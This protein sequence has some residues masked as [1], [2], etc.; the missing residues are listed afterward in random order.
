LDQQNQSGRRWQDD[1][2][3]SVGYVG[4]CLAQGQGLAGKSIGGEVR[5]RISVLG[6]AHFVALVCASI[7]VILSFGG[8]TSKPRAIATL[9][10]ADASLH[11]QAAFANSGDAQS[12]PSFVRRPMY[13]YSVIPGGVESAQELK[14]AV[15]RD[16]V[17]A[18]HYADFDFA[19]A[20]VVRLPADRAMYASYRIGDRVFWTTKTLKLRK[21][22]AVLSD[23][24]HE[25]RARCGN[26]LSYTPVGPVSP[27]EPPARV[28]ETPEAP[29]LIA[30]NLPPAAP[31]FGPPFTPPAPPATPPG[32]PPGGIIPPVF[33]PPIGGGPIP[34]HPKPPPVPMP[35]PGAAPLLVIGLAALLS[36]SW[37]L[38]IRRKR[39]A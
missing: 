16:S 26:R 4:L 35:E 27:E 33:W 37:F 9:S 14:N 18:G 25:A 30:D 23:G 24:V 19:K 22:E 28:M 38:R 31:P 34:N 13:P 36:A 10:A 6:W 12:S 5:S 29:I 2:S 3:F 21:G 8:R 20:R 39:K 11:E 32:T 7:A 15:L 17:V 1:C